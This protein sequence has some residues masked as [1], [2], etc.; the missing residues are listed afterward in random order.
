MR[1]LQNTEL[2]LESLPHLLKLLEDNTPFIRS[3]VINQLLN[4]GI[5]L[6]QEISRQEIELKP[7]QKKLLNKFIRPYLKEKNLDNKLDKFQIFKP[8]M[9]VSHKKYSYRGLI[10]DADPVCKA[11]ND[12]Y[13]KNQTQPEKNQPW[14]HVLV[15]NSGTVTYAAQ[16][17]LEMDTTEDQI[18]H[19]LIPFY[20]T[21]F[22][23]GVYLRNERKWGK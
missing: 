5:L 17:S 1:N 8:G 23:S 9:L 7:E 11:S 21:G 4:Y 2:D 3:T 12:W 10:V 19:P 18:L 13:E 6:D 16:T 22:D 15:H 14:Y 20:F